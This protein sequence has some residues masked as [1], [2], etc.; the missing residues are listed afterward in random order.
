MAY[1]SVVKPAIEFGGSAPPEN[2]KWG[3]NDID[4]ASE[5]LTYVGI[6][7]ISGNWIIFKIDE[8]SGISIRWASQNN[9]SSITSYSTAWQNRTTLNYATY[10]EAV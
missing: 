9:N 7:N 3:I 8:S 4:E 10:K 6:E 1:K 5:T 2:D